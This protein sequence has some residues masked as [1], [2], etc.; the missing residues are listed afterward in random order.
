M[1]K[2]YHNPS[3]MILTNFM[4]DVLS[5][6]PNSKDYGYFDPDWVF[7]DQGGIIG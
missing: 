6:S 1:K 2:F 5:A 7:D 4:E 3:F